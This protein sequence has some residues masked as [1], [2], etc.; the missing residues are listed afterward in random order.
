MATTIP[1]TREIKLTLL[2]WLRQGYVDTVELH[3][4][5]DAAD[6]NPDE[7]EAELDRLVMLDGSKEC[8]RLKRLGLCKC[9]R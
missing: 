5:Q 2:N 7:V 6:L 9:S 1:L 3:A 4:L 8:E